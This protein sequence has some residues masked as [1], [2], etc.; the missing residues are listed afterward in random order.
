MM[1]QNL[2]LQPEEMKATASDIERL[3]S[4]AQQVQDLLQRSWQRLD[5]GWQSYARENVDGY[6]R[7]TLQELA[8]AQQMLEQI[9]T[10]LRQTVDLLVAADQ[11]SVGLF[12]SDPGTTGRASRA[13]EDIV[14]G[15]LGS[16]GVT[17]VPAQERSGAVL[18]AM[19][20]ETSLTP[21]LSESLGLPDFA[22]ISWTQRF[23]WVDRLDKEIGKIDDGLR[24]LDQAIADDTA[25]I[26]GIDVE[27]R[28]LRAKRAEL[29]AKAD[30]WRNKWKISEDGLEFGLDDK[31]LD[32]PW[33]TRSDDYEEQIAALDHQIAE[34]EERREFHVQ[35]REQI[36][37]RRDILDGYKAEVIGAHDR[38]G[39]YFEK[40]I[41]MD[42]PSAKHPYFP[43]TTSSQCTKYASSQ[44]AVPC[45]GHA[46]EWYD[47]AKNAGYEVG[48]QPVKGAVMVWQPDVHGGDDE[49][50]HVSVVQRVETLDNGQLRVYYTDNNNHNVSAPSHVD[51][52]VGEEGVGFIYDA[53]PEDGSSA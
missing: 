42:G 21:D 33:K 43:G 46:Y 14:R 7:R 2:R 50:G 47:Q 15:A 34:L 3:G 27:L 24:R 32:A 49:Y 10:T 30:D 9:A 6:Y 39:N 29:Q 5:Y 18:G 53:L 45:R 28:S 41:G 19:A 13:V 51:I 48:A 4:E 38:L 52:T 17:T 31:F 22:K 23:A 44:R 37:E 26:E 16:L 35:H 40:G 36:V 8:R 11:E 20:G 12:E 1:S 25:S